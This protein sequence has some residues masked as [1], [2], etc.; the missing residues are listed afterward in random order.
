MRRSSNAQRETCELFLRRS[1]TQLL[2]V[3]EK[4]ETPEE[5]LKRGLAL[6]FGLKLNETVKPEI[7]APIFLNKGNT[8]SYHICILPLMEHDYTDFVPTGAQQLDMKANNVIIQLSELKNIVIYDLITRYTV[9]LFKQH[10]S[11][12]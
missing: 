5:A 1:A 9:D 11:L 6:E 7:L 8:A 3:I 12:F 4:H 2:T 10:Y